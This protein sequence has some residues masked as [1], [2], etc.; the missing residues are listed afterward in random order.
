MRWTIFA[1]GK[2][3]A[4]LTFEAL[5]YF[6]FAVGK[7]PTS[8]HED[9]LDAARGKSRDVHAG[10]GV[11]KCQREGV[12]LVKCGRGSACHRGEH[13]I[14]ERPPTATGIDEQSLLTVNCPP[15]D[16]P[17]SASSV[18]MH[19]GALRLFR[20]G[21]YR[22][23]KPSIDSTHAFTADAIE[24]AFAQLK[25]RRAKGKLVVQVS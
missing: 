20:Q 10:R 16:E 25:S 22:I 24:V 9:F 23:S 19:A 1:V 17:L 3:P 14:E 15:S 6:I 21:C 4:A 8:P 5:S 13:A 12:H 7:L 2:L 11:G 18:M